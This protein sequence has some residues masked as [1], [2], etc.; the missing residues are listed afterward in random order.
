VLANVGPKCTKQKERNA[1]ELIFNPVFIFSC[2]INLGRDKERARARERERE[3][4][5]VRGGRSAP[6][7]LIRVST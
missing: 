5:L 1:R 3:N 6:L 2:Q 4:F 7:F